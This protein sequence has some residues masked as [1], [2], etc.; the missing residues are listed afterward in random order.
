MQVWSRPADGHI[1]VMTGPGGLFDVGPLTESSFG[2][3]W[4][5]ALTVRPP[6]GLPRR[7]GR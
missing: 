2:L 4:E 1:G 6:P 5:P 3:P 7:V